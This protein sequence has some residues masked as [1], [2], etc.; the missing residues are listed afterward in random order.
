M[1]SSICRCSNPWITSWGWFVSFLCGCFTNYGRKSSCERWLDSH[2]KAAKMKVCVCQEAL[3]VCQ[4][5]SCH[6]AGPPCSVWR[7]VLFLSVCN[8]KLACYRC[9][10]C[11]VDP[12]AERLIPEMYSTFILDSWSE[13]PRWMTPMEVVPSLP[14]LSLRHRLVMYQHTFQPM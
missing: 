3:P 7:C 14:F 2:D 6:F 9:L 5:V 1:K 8:I 10:C 4:P 12:L 11:C 13:Q